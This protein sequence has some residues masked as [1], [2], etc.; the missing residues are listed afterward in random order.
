VF[1][2]ERGRKVNAKAKDDQEES[3]HEEGDEEKGRPKEGQA[4]AQEEGQE[5]N[6]HGQI[7]LSNALALLIGSWRQ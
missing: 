2:V 7:V 6:G 3:R 1:D 5:E 4:Q